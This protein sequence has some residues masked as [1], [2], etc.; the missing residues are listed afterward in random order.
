MKTPEAEKFI[1]N[2][3]TRRINLFNQAL[4][5]VIDDKIMINEDSLEVKEAW[6]NYKDSGFLAARNRHELCEAIT[7]EHIDTRETVQTTIKKVYQQIIDTIPGILGYFDF[8]NMENDG[9]L[10]ITRKSY[11]DEIPSKNKADGKTTTGKEEK[12]RGNETESFETTKT[13]NDWNIVEGKFEPKIIQSNPNNDK[14]GL[15]KNKFEDLDTSDDISELYN[16]DLE[17]H[18]SQETKYSDANSPKNT[19]PAEIMIPLLGVNTLCTEI[20]QLIELYCDTNPEPSWMH[21]WKQWTDNDFTNVTNVPQ[22]AVCVEAPSK[23]VTLQSVYDHMAT[24]IDHLK[25][26]YE[27]RHFNGENYLIEKEHNIKNK[28]NNNRNPETIKNQISNDE[29]ETIGNAIAQGN[30]TDLDINLLCTWIMNKGNEVQQVCDKVEQVAKRGTEKMEKAVKDDSNTILNTL[31]KASHKFSQQI[32]DITHDAKEEF[33]TLHI[34]MKEVQDK[35]HTN[36][37]SQQKNLDKAKGQIKKAENEGVLTINKT[38]NDHIS[39]LNTIVSDSTELIDKLIGTTSITNSKQQ[40]IDNMMITLQKRIHG[41][42][43]KFEEMICMQTDKER[44]NFIQW[45]DKRLKILKQQEGDGDIINQLMMKHDKLVTALDI[46]AKER[47]KLN[48]ERIM[49]EGDRNAFQ[50]WWNAIKGD[51]DNGGH[52]NTPPPINTN[53]NMTHD[54]EERPSEATEQQSSSSS[55]IYVDKNSDIFTF[56]VVDKHNDHPRR[57]PSH[58]I[59]PSTP[60]PNQQ[61]QKVDQFTFNQF[62]RGVDKP[63][64]HGTHVKYHQNIYKYHGHINYDDNPPSYINDTWYY[65]IITTKNVKLINCSEKYMEDTVEVIPDE[66]RK[67]IRQSRGEYIPYQSSVPDLQQS[68]DSKLPWEEHPTAEPT[69]PIQ[70]EYVTQRY[71]KRDTKHQDKPWTRPRLAPNEFVFPLETHPIKVQHH[72]ITKYGNKWEITIQSKEEF[73]SFYEN[74]RNQMNTYHVYLIE[75]DKIQLDKSLTELTEQNCENYNVAV[76]EMSRAIFNFFSSNKDKIFETYTD[77]IHSLETYRPYSNGFG[78]LMNMMKRLHPTLKR[79]MISTDTGVTKMPEYNQ[80]S[81]I[82]KFINAL[83]AYRKDE[84]QVGRLFSDKELL[85]HIC[86]SLDERF[87]SAIYKIQKELKDSFA[88]PSNPQPITSYLTLDNELALR[89]LELID[90]EDREQDFTNSDPISR[91][92]INR[93]NYKERS[94][95]YQSGTNNDSSSNE[96]QRRY[97]RNKY[98]SQTSKNYKTQTKTN[99]EKWA[100]TLKWEIIEGAE[101]AGCRRNNHDVYRTGCPAFAQ[102]ALC[103]DFYKTVPKDQLDKVKN[104][105]LQHQKSRKKAM[106]SK[107]REYRSTIKTLQADP[108]Y[109][110]NV[111]AKLRKTF[112][113]KYKEEFEEERHL[114]DNPFENDDNLD[115]SME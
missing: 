80:Y 97:N 31:E 25:E 14:E 34:K 62:P 63:K 99:D 55:S 65:D 33:K 87:S 35:S 53:I 57:S 30:V 86:K 44:I 101:C 75:Y 83:V 27:L 36:V 6:N 105:F 26:A 32:L 23:L 11:E 5:K 98:D 92:T 69:A 42:T 40:E 111:V 12:G 95:K 90:D 41:A 74:L 102:F 20:H 16:E 84:A 52:N 3:T 9:N 13:K 21:I 114:D 59:D 71:D 112:F 8:H 54:E 51:F 4:A 113:D 39:S 1:M 46:V 78:F 85:L 38:A 37:K 28:T 96:S 48:A 81:T 91:A 19:E 79:T 100:E 22:L 45:M 2:G 108:D 94:N 10:Y 73:R 61:V 67:G 70:R 109:D 7:G 18:L 72:D 76:N 49:L 66:A 43:D 58:K 115:E 107:K 64:P 93:T 50:Q 104:A 15:Q 47:M 88:D 17:R 110:D 29:I 82:H 24:K 68:N 60:Q 103:Q 89:I 106:N 56:K 77:P